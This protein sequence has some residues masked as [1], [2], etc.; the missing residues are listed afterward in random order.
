VLK[1]TDE[2]EVASSHLE[3][4]CL[5]LSRRFGSILASSTSDGHIYIFSIGITDPLM[6][7]QCVNGDGKVVALSFDVCEELLLAVYSSGEICVWNLESEEIV[8]QWRTKNVSLAATFHP[9][10]VFVALLQASQI[11]LWNLQNKSLI[12]VYPLSEKYKSSST[13]LFSPDGLYLVCGATDN[14]KASALVFDLERGCI[15]H[16]LCD[17]SDSNA[18]VCALAFHPEEAILAIGSLSG[19]VTFWDFVTFQSLDSPAPQTLVSSKINQLSWSYD[20]SCLMAM[21]HNYIH[22][23]KTRPSN[24]I[25]F[26][27]TLTI[28]G[29]SKINQLS[30]GFDSYAIVTCCSGITITTWF[31]NLQSLGLCQTRTNKPSNESTTEK[32]NDPPTSEPEVVEDEALIAQLSNNKALYTLRNRLDH[33]KTLRATLAG[34][35][36][37]SI[38]LALSKQA[39]ATRPELLGELLSGRIV[40]ASLNINSATLG[41]NGLTQTTSED[42]TLFLNLLKPNLKLMSESHQMAALTYLH[43]L[44]N[45]L[46]NVCPE[47]FDG[48]LE[49]VLKLSELNSGSVGQKAKVIAIQINGSLGNIE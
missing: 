7:L 34:K 20:G 39:S 36:S 3:V 47:K 28:D 41:P 12:H 44:V 5:A 25:Q 10:G 23:W 13:L 15:V 9:S 11:E 35:T 24:S 42:L 19:K 16:S 40:E 14:G 1:I 49:E 38:W 45:D 6:V 30:F 18:S 2:I 4:T 22:I 27:E 31:F 17:A 29:A 33:L 32:S 48:I 21:V 46:A 43:Q 37:P 26:V 8:R